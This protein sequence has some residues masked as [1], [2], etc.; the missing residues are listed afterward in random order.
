[1][2]LRSH[3]VRPMLGSC[4]RFLGSE[5]CKQLQGW[6]NVLQS[7]IMTYQVVPCSF[8]FACTSY[9]CLTLKVMGKMNIVFPNFKGQGQYLCVIKKK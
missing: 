4:R 9:S 6:Q 3:V 2:A 5:Q 8:R 1:M 7:G